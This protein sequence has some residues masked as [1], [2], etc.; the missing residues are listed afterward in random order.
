MSPT[1]SPSK[2]KIE[3]RV[4]K[5]LSHQAAHGG[6]STALMYEP[7]APEEVAHGRLFFVLDIA[8]PLPLSPDIAYNLIDIVKEEY[9]RDLELTPAESFENALKAAN[10]ELAAIYKEGVKDWLG[11]FNCIIAAARGTDLYVVQRGT[12]EVHLLRSSQIVNLS[13]GMYSPGET[14]RAE[15]TLINLIE[16]EIELGDKFIFSTSELFYYISIE[17]LKRLME[18]NT[19]AQAAKKLALQLEQELDINRTSVMVAEFNMP[20]I[21]SEDDV[22]A[23]ASENWIGSPKGEKANSGPAGFKKDEERRAKSVAEALEEEPVVAA[24]VVQKFREEEVED[25]GDDVIIDE[26]EETHFRTPSTPLLNLSNIKRPTLETFESL[27]NSI[28]FGDYKNKLKLDSGKFK[29]AGEAA[30]RVSK[31]VGVVGV[32][33]IQSASRGITSW[34]KAMKRR[35]NGNKVLMGVV[36]GLALLV[37]LSTIGI[38]RGYTTRVTTKKATIA[39]TD[40]TQKRNEAQAALIYGDTPKARTLLAEAFALASSAT[41]NRKLGSEAQAL[42]TDLQ[43]Q[44]DEVSGVKRFT[45]VQPVVNFADLN[46]QLGGTAESPK[47]AK[48]SE[49]T[50]LAGN[51]YAIDPDN[52]K[53]YKYKTASGEKAIVN[54]LVSDKKLTQVS[55]F[56]DKELA[57]FTN[58]GSAYVLNTENNTMTARNLDSGIWSNATKM[59]SY[60]DKLYLL[61]PASNEIWRYRTVPEGY[62]KIASYFDGAKPTLTGAIDFVIDGSVYVLMPNNVIK[63]YS[64]GTEINFNQLTVPSPYQAIGQLTDIFVDASRLYVLDAPNH[65]VLAYDKE[66]SYLNQFIFEGIDNPTNL[67]VDDPAGQMYLTSG[68]MVYKL[69]I[70]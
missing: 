44:L 38:S 11:K 55:T 15:E 53:I 27:K 5:V 58:P 31:V 48:V 67:V 4:G 63:K 61:D 69:P 70:K 36:I 65:R 56:N 46:P 3:A 29:S 17:K 57:L 39:I 18:A 54:S 35:K 37:V 64:G 45:D 26:S 2:S 8:S 50:L 28:N 66:G 62:T 14:Y 51:V 40:A 41:S 19:P 59:I 13:K 42:V 23:V 24:P 32:A 6:F 22:E 16:G 10:D 33:G 25:G 7:D 30:A 20:E 68:T 21:L 12:A 49:I 9:Y 60:T 34:V 43:K 47:S 1:F 52:N